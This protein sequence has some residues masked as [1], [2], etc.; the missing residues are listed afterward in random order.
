MQPKAKVKAKRAPMLDAQGRLTNVKRKPKPT[1][2]TVQGAP[3]PVA[4]PKQRAAKPAPVPKS[5]VVQRPQPVTPQP[6][7]AQPT[8]P[9]P[10][11]FPQQGQPVAVPYGPQQMWTGGTPGFDERTGQPAKQPEWM[12]PSGAYKGAPGYKPAKVK[13][14]KW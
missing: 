9:Q 5:P 2:P 3:V 1:K 6:V 8:A 7:Q 4:T 11:P 10:V 14:P 12:S 13:T